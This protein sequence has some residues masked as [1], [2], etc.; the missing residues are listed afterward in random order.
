MSLSLHIYS[1]IFVTFSKKSFFKFQSFVIT[2]MGISRNN[3]NT[4]AV[5]VTGSY[6]TITNGTI[7]KRD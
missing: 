1:N 5:K 7:E 3:N 6:T 4:L 2:V